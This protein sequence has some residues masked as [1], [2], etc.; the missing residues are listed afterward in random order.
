MELIRQVDYRAAAYAFIFTGLWFVLGAL[1]LWVE[2]PSAMGIGGEFFAM[3]LIIFFLALGASGFV[4]S[5]AALNAAFPPV[6]TRAVRRRATRQAP[7]RSR[8]SLWA[9]PTP[10]DSGPSAAPS[11]PHPRSRTGT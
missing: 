3:W 1:L 4:L 10:R 11:P 5:A 7:A 2:L 8:E 9:P 6:E